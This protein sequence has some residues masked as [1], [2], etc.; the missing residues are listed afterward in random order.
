MMF[1]SDFEGEKVRNQEA[2]PPLRVSR[3]E[4]RLTVYRANA[5]SAGQRG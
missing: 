2:A 3:P 5:V 4:T 1:E